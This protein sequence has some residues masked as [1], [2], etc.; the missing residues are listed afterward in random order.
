MDTGIQLGRRFRALKLWMVLRYFGAAGVRARLEEHVRLAQ[1][2]AGWVDQTPGWERIAPVPFSVVCFRHRPPG[3]DDE[4]E[5][6]RRNAAI[7]DR[8]NQS[9]EVFLSHTKL[10]GRF[11]LR[12]AIG[13]IRTEERHVARAWALLRDAA[14][15]AGA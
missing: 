10:D 12:L 7:L 1:L 3:L 9:G 2:V 5:L 15:D 6:E 14:A 11:L 13:N 4:R 8:V